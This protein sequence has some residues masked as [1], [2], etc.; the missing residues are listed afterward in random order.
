MCTYVNEF[1]SFQAV[2]FYNIPIAFTVFL[3]VV[4][5][6]NKIGKLVYNLQLVFAINSNNLFLF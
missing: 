1:H 6:N 3:D 2:V 4:F 5:C